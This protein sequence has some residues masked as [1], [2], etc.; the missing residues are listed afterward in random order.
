M[1]SVLVSAG[2]TGFP[3]ALPTTVLNC[4]CVSRAQFSNLQSLPVSQVPGQVKAMGR[5][6]LRLT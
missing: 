1:R 3:C 2:E 6:S 5:G 4:P